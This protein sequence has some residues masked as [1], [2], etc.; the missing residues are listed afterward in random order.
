MQ[1][2][3]SLGVVGAGDYPPDCCIPCPLLPTPV[4]L[5]TFSTSQVR[6]PLRT[7]FS[8]YRVR[9]QNPSFYAKCCSRC[10]SHF[11][12]NAAKDASTTAYPFPEHLAR[13]DAVVTPRQK[14][15]PVEC[16]K[17]GGYRALSSYGVLH[18]MKASRLT[19]KYKYNGITKEG[20]KKET[21]KVITKAQQH[22]L[23]WR[24]AAYPIK[25]YLWS[26]RNPL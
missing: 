10:H 5:P 13:N 11:E 26:D 3:G 1:P 19:C 22:S 23:T 15:D 4:P 7:S 25:R 21:E 16:G 12:K 17:S 18:K 2:R 6:F 9:S 24:V 8:F 20:K 14:P